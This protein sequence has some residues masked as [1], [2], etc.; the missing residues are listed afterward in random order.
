M[1]FHDLLIAVIIIIITTIIWIIVSIIKAKTYNKLWG[2]TDKIEILW[3][4]YPVLILMLI[5]SP[6][7][8]IL[9]L[10]EELT[11]YD[12]VIKIIGHQWYWTYQINELNVNFDSYISRE[13]ET[14]LF[15]LLEVDNRLTLPY[16]TNIILLVTSTDVI[17]SWSVPSLTLKIDAVPGRLNRIIFMSNKAGV[18][19]GQCSEICGVNHRFMPINVE[20]VHINIL[21]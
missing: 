11:I 19:W 5:V 15:R 10:I 6:S 13:K 21:F 17:H 12:I 9:Y 7:I 8:R 16:L 14:S 3:T 2:N 20:F 18:F 4:F 1:Q